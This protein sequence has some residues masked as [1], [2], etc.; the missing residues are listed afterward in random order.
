MCVPVCQKGLPRRTCVQNCSHIIIVAPN[1]PLAAASCW[2]ALRLLNWAYSNLFT[3]LCYVLLT[4]NAAIYVLCQ[5]ML[6][7]MFSATVQHCMNC[8]ISWTSS[9]SFPMD[10][11]WTSD[12]RFRVFHRI[13]IRIGGNFS[14][15]IGLVGT[16]HSH[17]IWN[18]I[19]C[20]HTFRPSIHC[21]TPLMNN[22][23]CRPTPGPS[24]TSQVNQ[25]SCSESVPIK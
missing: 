4:V 23:L 20:D 2:Y 16:V 7:S 25:D 15:L 1:G 24:W 9:N 5:L 13:L 18:L 17:S 14:N 10:E 11:G 6:L 8:C 12:Y 3:V 22:C 19:T 21:R